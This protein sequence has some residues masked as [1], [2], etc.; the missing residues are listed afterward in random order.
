MDR[1]ADGD[2][3]GDGDGREA[4]RTGYDHV[5]DVAISVQCSA[6]SPI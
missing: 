3:D 5:K 2:G 4:R 6:V 1:E